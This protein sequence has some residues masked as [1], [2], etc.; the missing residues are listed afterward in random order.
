MILIL[1][2]PVTPALSW[3]IW[4]FVAV[5]VIVRALPAHVPVPTWLP[6]G[7]TEPAAVAS[8]LH[9][10]A[11]SVGRVVSSPLTHTMKAPNV[12]IVGIFVTTSLIGIV[13]KLKSLALIEKAISS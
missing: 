5:E 7:V 2:F 9:R 10:E 3:A 13:K 8:A 1:K 4:K 11:V 12:G 6:I